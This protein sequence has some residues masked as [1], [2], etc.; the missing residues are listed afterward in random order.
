[1]TKRAVL[2][3]LIPF[4]IFCQWQ[5]DI[6][7]HGITDDTS[8]NGSSHWLV[9]EE[10]ID[11]Y[12]YGKIYRSTINTSPFNEE[13]NCY[14]YCTRKP[15]RQSSVTRSQ[16]LLDSLAASLFH[17]YKYSRKYQMQVS[18]RCTVRSISILC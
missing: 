10:V 18:R 11:D 6:D 17:P 7:C 15:A 12:N 9:S 5:L 16:V 14:S 13:L 3:Y 4:V 1:M 8:F 2:I